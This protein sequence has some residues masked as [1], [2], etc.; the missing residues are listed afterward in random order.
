MLAPSNCVRYACPHGKDK[1]VDCTSHAEPNS[2]R[3]L[4]AECVS[5]YLLAVAWN[6][7]TASGIPEILN[8]H[9]RIF[10]GS[11]KTAVV[12]AWKS[13]LLRQ[14]SKLGDTGDGVVRRRDD[15]PSWSP[16]W[17]VQAFPVPP[18]EI[19]TTKQEE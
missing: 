18:P 10:E 13:Y 5:D 14:F 2:L 8:C 19:W 16:A 1:L 7:G 11:S 15:G 12:L 3:F 6:L 4:K 9:K 17:M